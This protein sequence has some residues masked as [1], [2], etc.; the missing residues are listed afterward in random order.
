LSVVENGSRNSIHCKWWALIKY[1]WI[2]NSFKIIYIAQF[3]YILIITWSLSTVVGMIKID[4]DK[5]CR[6]IAG[7]FDHH[8]VD[9]AV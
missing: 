8:D 6:Q 4:G 9:G 7:D 1:Q 2:I 5:K 3:Y